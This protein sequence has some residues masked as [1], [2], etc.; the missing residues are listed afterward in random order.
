MESEVTL[1]KGLR[2]IENDVVAMGS[3]VEKAIERAVEALRS[4]T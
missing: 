4:E 2:E 3:M 1:Q